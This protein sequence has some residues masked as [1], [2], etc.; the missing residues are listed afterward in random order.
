MAQ[1]RWQRLSRLA[2]APSAAV[3]QDSGN[4][5]LS[6]PWLDALEASGAV[7]PGTGW[8]PCHLLFRRDERPAALLPLYLKSDSRG[9]YVFDQG[10]AAAWRRHGLPYYPKLVTAI[11][12]TPV[13]GPRLLLAPG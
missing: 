8:Q 7:G 3:W 13:P 4:P 12:F 2:D 10:W 6:L 9:E 5:F 11:P 1:P